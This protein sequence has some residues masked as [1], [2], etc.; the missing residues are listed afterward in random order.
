MNQRLLIIEISIVVEELVSSTLGTFLDID[1]KT[2]ET[3]GSKSSALSFN[4]KV[5]IIQDLKTVD[6]T[7]INKLNC[8]MMIRN[9]FAHVGEIKS[10]E[11]LFTTTSN[12]IEIKKNLL[13]W[14]P[15]IKEESNI[16]NDYFI[17]FEKLVGDIIDFLIKIS[18][19]HAFNKGYI[20]GKHEG[21]N[22]LCNELISEIRK[23]DGG[24]EIINEILENVKNKINK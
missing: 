21:T 20:Q 5:Q 19:E 10:L 12:G 13:K 22:L 4:Q 1:W 8:L 2:S 7:M 18:K 15:N 24:Q 17:Y 3:L 14:Y 16:P 23:F 9:K 11:K 6:K